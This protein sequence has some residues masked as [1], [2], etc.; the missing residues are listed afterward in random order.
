MEAGQL[1]FPGDSRLQTISCRIEAVC[2]KTLP[3]GKLSFGPG[4]PPKTA[5]AAWQNSPLFEIA[6]LLARFNHVAR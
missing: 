2:V 3:D 5:Q 4:L 6:R 1:G